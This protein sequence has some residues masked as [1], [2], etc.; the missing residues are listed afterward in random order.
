MRWL[1]DTDWPDALAGCSVAV[2]VILLGYV[3]AGRLHGG[4]AGFLPG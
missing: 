2:P 3:T 1:A 4:L